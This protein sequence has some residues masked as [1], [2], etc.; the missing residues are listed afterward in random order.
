MTAPAA[1]L[2]AASITVLGLCYLIGSAAGLLAGAI[3]LTALAVLGTR[4]TLSEPARTVGAPPT[5]A[6]GRPAYPT[7]RKLAVTA[8]WAG[9][10]WHAW[11]RDVRPR[12]ARLVDVALAD[13]YGTDLAHRPDLGRRVL[14]PRLW[15]LVDPDRPRSDDRDTPGPSRRT[16]EQILT[17]LEES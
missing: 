6:T 8:G 1:V 9:T 10:S 13:R 14:G 16:L 17:R 12:L 4:A 7:L 3:V 11:D 15:E 2:S 5:G